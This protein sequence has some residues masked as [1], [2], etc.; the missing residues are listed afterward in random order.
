MPVTFGGK[1]SVRRLRNAHKAQRIAVWGITDPAG[2][3]IAA[4]TSGRGFVRVEDGFIRSVGLGSDIRP[5]GSLVIDDLG[6]YYDATRPSR[7][8]QLI[9][10]GPFDAV[11]LARAAWLRAR[12][13]ELAL[14][15]YNLSGP[16][17]AALPNAGGRQRVLVVEQ[18]P[19][20][21]ALKLGTAH[22]TT[23]AALLTAVRAAKP[24]AHIIYK[25]HPDLVAG[26]R[27]GRLP[28]QRIRQ[29][30]DHVVSQGDMAQ[31][32]GAV[33]EIHV[34]SSLAGFEALCRGTRVV[35]WG[36]PFYGGWGLTEDRVTFARRTRV[37]T[38]DEVV[39]A[40]LIL[41]PRYCD[42]VGGVPCSVEEFVGAIERLRAAGRMSPMPG[43]VLRQ[44]L[45]QWGRLKR[46]VVAGR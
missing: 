26:N 22:I 5:A 45:H 4:R 39:A 23:N 15:K 44:L 28:L 1:A 43:G 29:Y 36:R 8:E 19:G 24:E 46:T 25:E 21:A 12:L 27:A 14:T 9:N 18:V 10:D 37:A 2:F 17:L 42:P 31:L 38:L 13:A 11:L 35:V 34:M 40:T 7:L 3:E 30:A 20:D 32:Y 6:L 41:Y 16:T 33:D